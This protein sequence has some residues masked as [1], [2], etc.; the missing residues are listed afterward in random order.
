[1][2]LI[3]IGLAGAVLQNLTDGLFA[4]DAPSVTV[5]AGK[6]D[7]YS[8]LQLRRAKENGRLPTTCATDLGSVSQEQKGYGCTLPTFP[9]LY[10]ISSEAIGG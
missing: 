2:W 5:S 9:G 4:L 3:P 6:A 1:M 7:G 8:R 10:W